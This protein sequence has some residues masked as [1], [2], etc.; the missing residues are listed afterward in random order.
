MPQLAAA[1]DQGDNPA[2][3]RLPVAGAAVPGG[4]VVPGQLRESKP[5]L[6]RPDRPV[7]E[8]HD[9]HEGRKPGKLSAGRMFI[10]IRNSLQPVGLLGVPGGGASRLEKTGGLGLW[11]SGLVKRPGQGGLVAAS[12]APPPGEQRR[13]RNPPHS[14][15]Q[16]LGVNRDG[17]AELMLYVTLTRRMDRRWDQR[18]AGRRP[19]VGPQLHQTGVIPAVGADEASIARPRGSVEPVAPCGRRSAADEARGRQQVVGGPGGLGGVQIDVNQA[20]EPAAQDEADVVV[21][22]ER[23]GP[24]GPVR[25]VRITGPFEPAGTRTTRQP[26]AT[27]AAATAR[28]A[29]KSVPA[30]C[31]P[32]ARADSGHCR[33][34]SFPTGRPGLKNVEKPGGVG[35][36]PAGDGRL[37]LDLAR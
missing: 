23:L 29:G 11:P 2:S 5:L 17:P 8:T 14:P 35:P 19:S 3:L 13:G 25:P 37:G 31:A 24:V 20:A 15:G 1:P 21:R 9:L 33:P 27:R 4:A 10:R 30:I 34:G 6:Q 36:S 22:G 26:R 12:L 18:P 7:R 28:W 16:G 32:P